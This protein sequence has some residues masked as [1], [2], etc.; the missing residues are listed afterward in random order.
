VSGIRCQVS[1][2]IPPTEQQDG[3]EPKANHI[4]AVSGAGTGEVGTDL[5]FDLPVADE[6]CSGRLE[7]RGQGSGLNPYSWP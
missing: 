7:T 3:G 6:I 4:D 5:L 2:P 1:G